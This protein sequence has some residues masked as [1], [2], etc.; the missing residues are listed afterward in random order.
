MYR[1]KHNPPLP[2]RH[3]RA[4]FK[5]LEIL[6]SCLLLTLIGISLLPSLRQSARQRVLMEQQ[7]DALA[8]VNAQLEWARRQPW[9]QI[10]HT[11]QDRLRKSDRLSQLP[12]AQ[13]TVQ[14]TPTEGT[15]AGKRIDVRLDWQS[16]LNLPAPPVQMSTWVFQPGER[17]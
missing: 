12:E 7:I 1:V 6:V 5:L 13:F 2:R 11:L 16:E 9:N 17:T 3:H 10:D 8:E 15:P 14:V 4:A